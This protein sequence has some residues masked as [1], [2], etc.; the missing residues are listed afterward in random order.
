VN[1]DVI[2]QDQLTRYSR[3]FAPE[4]VVLS[5]RDPNSLACYILVYSHAGRGV[6]V[7]IPR[8]LPSARLTIRRTLE[9]L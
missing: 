9:N 8:T 5:V 7:Q 6:A 2:T 1:A 3:K 4:S